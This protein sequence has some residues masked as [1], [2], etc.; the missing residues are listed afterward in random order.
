MKNLSM[1]KKDLLILLGIVILSAPISYFL[2]L[3]VRKNLS[4][5]PAFFTGLW[6]LGLI[7]ICFFS[8]LESRDKDP[9]VT[10]TTQRMG[11]SNS[12]TAALFLI[13]VNFRWF[14][15][16]L[17][18][19]LLVCICLFISREFGR[20]SRKK[21]ETKYLNKTGVLLGD[22]PN[23]AKAEINGEQV[24]VWSK[25]TIKAGTLIYISEIKATYLYVSPVEQISD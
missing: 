21:R 6:Y 23:K 24:T 19:A 13:G 20:Y 25:D 11:V 16:W 17:V 8:Y 14:T 1:R 15:G 2:S 5:I 18:S 9:F 7:F 4:E 22:L 10:G 3:N 12:F